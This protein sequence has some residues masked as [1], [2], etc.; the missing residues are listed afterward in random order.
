MA[1]ELAVLMPVVI[2]VA[3][4]A[5]NLLQFSELC[6]RFDRVALDSVLVSGVS[7]AGTDGSD[8]V[9]A[10]R[11]QLVHAMGEGFD[12]EVEVRAED[13]RAPGGQATFDLAAGTVRY[14]CVLG[15]RPWP[16]SLGMAGVSVRLPV[17]MRHERSFVVD[18]YRAAVIT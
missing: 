2:V 8:G 10:V 1:V 3:L 7:P 4:V 11:E 15:F 18:R 13:A 9:D 16:T 6:A 5:L 12:H 17:V 14:V